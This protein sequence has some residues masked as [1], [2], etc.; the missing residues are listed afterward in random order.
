M[1]LGYIVGDFSI[2]SGIVY[3]PP[4]PPKKE[5]DRRRPRGL[6][7]QYHELRR[8]A[9][10]RGRGAPAAELGGGRGSGDSRVGRKLN[11][12]PT[13]RVWCLNPFQHAV[14]HSWYRAS[15][16]CALLWYPNTWQRGS[17]SKHSVL[18][19]TRWVRCSEQAWAGPAQVAVSVWHLVMELFIQHRAVLRMLSS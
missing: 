11:E 4:P 2:M 5:T 10:G 16:P 1:I 7:L 17:Q 9:V 3:T 18:F 12:A 8:E 15:P 14:F 13:S 6:G 19:Y